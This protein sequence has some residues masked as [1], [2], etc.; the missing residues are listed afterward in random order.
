MIGRLSAIAAGAALFA[1][2]SAQAA[3]FAYSERT[4]IV[5]PI[6]E[7]G[8][9]AE[10]APV[11][12]EPRA[13]VVAPEPYVVIRR[14]YS[15]YVIERDYVAPREYVA[16]RVRSYTI[17]TDTDSYAYEPSAVVTTNYVRPGCFID[18]FGYERCD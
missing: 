13:Y 8:Y 16:P 1:A 11:V 17:E 4:T 3:D 18:R 5:E 10:P 6:V 15:R 2:S 9:V 14:P 12:V 7:P